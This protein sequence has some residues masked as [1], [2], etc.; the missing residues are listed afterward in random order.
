MKRLNRITP[1]LACAALFAAAPSG[2]TPIVSGFDAGLEGWKAVGFDFDV[3]IALPPSLNITKTDN[4]ADLAWDSGGDFDPAFDGNPGGF[5]RFED[6]ITNPGSFLEAPAQFTGDLSSYAGQTIKYDHRIFNEGANATSVGPYVIMLISGDLNDLNA[7][8]SVQPGPML[9]D[10]DTD[11][12]T[13]SQTLDAANFTAVAD[14]DLGIFDP[15]GSGITLSD[16]PLANFSTDKTFEEVLADVS[17]LI[18]S[19]EMVDNNSTQVS[20]TNGVDNV[21]LVPEPT[22]LALLGLGGLLVARRRR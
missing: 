17:S 18:I 21:M 2:A 8:V 1:A 10:A 13:V 6:E 5:A 4:S 16:I 12:V 14:V 9:G 7:Y 11:W 15:A 19:F 22:S 20:E 3:N